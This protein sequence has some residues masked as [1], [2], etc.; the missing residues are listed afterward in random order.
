MPLSPSITHTEA[1]A[2]VKE[3]KRAAFDVSKLSIAGKD[4]HTEEHVV[5]YDNTGDRMKY[6]GQARRILGRH[7]GVVRGHGVS[8][9]PRHRTGLGRRAARRV[10]PRRA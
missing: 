2:A 9:H 6:R 4:F 1:E 8:C 7:L 10:D 3:L 5:G